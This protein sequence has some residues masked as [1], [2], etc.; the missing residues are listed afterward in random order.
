MR[1]LVQ[2]I[3]AADLVPVRDADTTST[4]DDA[5]L[6]EMERRGVLRRGAG[7]VPSEI[8]ERGPRSRGRAASHELVEER[9]TGR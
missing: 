2:G 8:L 4:N 6:D 3:A 7:G 1:I 9:R 5:L